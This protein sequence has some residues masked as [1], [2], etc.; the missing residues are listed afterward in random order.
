MNVSITIDDAKV[1]EAL[2]RL[3]AKVQ[4]LRPALEKIGQEYEKR[5]RE[6]FDKE[7]DPEGNAWPKLSPITMMLAIGKK[8]GFSKKGGLNSFGRRR[9]TSKKLLYASGAL[10]TSIH[11]QTDSNSVIIG[12]T[13]NIKYAA[14]HQFGGKA[15]RGKKVTIPAR[16]YL[17]MKEGTNGLKLAGRDKKMILDI[18][19]EYLAKAVT[20]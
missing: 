10:S 6:N 3:A 15:G 1:Q 5:V 14:I 19:E 11:H 4:N 20:S 17:A 18:I 12:S 2:K 13:G 16:P 9:I 8:K 7:A